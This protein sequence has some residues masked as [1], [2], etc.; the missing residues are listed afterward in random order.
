VILAALSLHPSAS[1]PPGIF[2][3][4]QAKVKVSFHRAVTARSKAAFHCF[5]PRFYMHLVTGYGCFP[6]C[7]AEGCKTHPGVGT[8]GE[9]KS[10]T[11]IQQPYDS[12]V[13][14]AFLINSALD[15]G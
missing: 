4:L 2:I 15:L 10:P 13:E 5:Q 9:N 11:S 1:A 14:A 3:L 8:F 7:Q 12:L 6:K